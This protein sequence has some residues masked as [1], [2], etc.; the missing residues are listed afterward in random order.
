MSKIVFATGGATGIA[1]ATA[2]LY[3]RLQNDTNHSRT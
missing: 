1:T 3:N 2:S